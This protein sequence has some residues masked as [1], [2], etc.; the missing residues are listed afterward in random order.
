MDFDLPLG[1][2]VLERTPAALRAM[3]HGLDPAWIDG[4][5]GREVV[6]KMRGGDVKFNGQQYLLGHA[7]PNFYFH[8]ATAYNILR[9]NGVELGKMDYLGRS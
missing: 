6:L 7:L 5:E 9:H 4:T 8:V 3:L 1:I 2:S